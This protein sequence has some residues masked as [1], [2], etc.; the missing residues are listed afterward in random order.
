MR[1]AADSF[2]IAVNFYLRTQPAPETV[3]KFSIDVPEAMRSVKCAVEAFLHVQK[4]SNDASVVDKYLGLVLFLNHQRFS[5]DGQYLGDLDTFTRIILPKM[6]HGFPQKGATKVDFRQ[7][8]WLTGLRLLAGGQD[9]EVS[10][11]YQ[12]HHV[13]FAK[14]AAVP[15]PGLSRES[16]GTYFEFIMHEGVAAPVGYFLSA[17]LYGGAD[18][19]VTANKDKDDAFGHRDTMWMFQHYGF[20]GDEDKFPEAGIGFIEGVNRAL[21]PGLGAYNNYA[22]PSLAPGEAQ[23]LYYGEKLERLEML[24]GTLDPEDVFSHPQTIKGRKQITAKQ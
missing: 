10:I 23:R 14:S 24:K 2:G 5:I 11:N 19:Q 17:Q 12:E 20:V 13:F 18:S 3:I 16:L 15:H 9:L 1:G 21:G 6:L 7:V 8:D 22:D 4:L